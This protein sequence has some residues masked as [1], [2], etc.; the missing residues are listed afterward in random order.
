MPLRHVDVHEVA[1]DGAHLF[2]FHK[3]SGVF[4]AHKLAALGAHEGISAI[5]FDNLAFLHAPS[6]H[7]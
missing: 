4:A 7:A 6:F 1:D 2:A 5:K 3:R